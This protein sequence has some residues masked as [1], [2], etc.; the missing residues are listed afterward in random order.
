MNDQT[1][2]TAG[3]QGP[4]S[5]R[6][7]NPFHESQGA[8]GM[9]EVPRFGD[10]GP[11]KRF[12]PAA[13][14]LLRLARP[15]LLVFGI[16][17]LAGGGLGVAAGLLWYRFAPTVWLTIPADVVSQVKS[18]VDQSALLVV[19]EGKGIASVDGYYF[20]FT[21]LAGLLLGV[22]GFWLGRRGL[23]AGADRAGQPAG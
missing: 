20:V 21:A 7:R 19:P 3:G 18:N 2:P 13:A 14:R 12:A 16:L 1:S 22:L 17:L 8:Q 11:A 10:D 6:G 9:P 23:A 15:D 4:G 5:P